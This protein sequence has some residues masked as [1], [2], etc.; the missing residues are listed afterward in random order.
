M[1]LFMPSGKKSG[2]RIVLL[3]AALLFISILRA[4]T[5]L[6][7]STWSMDEHFFI[8]FSVGFL[9]YNLNPHWFGY[10]TLPMYI[11]SGM[12]A[13]LYWCFRLIGLVGSKV[14]F[15]ALLFE[16]DAV[17][18]ISA[19]LL[20]S[21][22]H[23]LGLFVL[24]F[25]VYRYYRSTL[26]A[27]LVFAAGMLM[28]DS[29]LASN[30]VRVDS[31]VFLFLCLLILFSC[32]SKKNRSS[33]IFS[34]IACAAAIASKIPALALFPVLLFGLVIDIRQ[35]HYSK[36]HLAYSLVGVPLL[37]LLFMPY[38]VLDFGAYKQFLA[39]LTA[40]ASGAYKG[41][42]YDL[43]YK[44]ILGKLGNLIRLIANQT[45]MVA[46]AGTAFAGLYALLR[47]KTNFLLVFLYTLAYT[48]TFSTSAF[49]AS[50]W[51]RPV[52]PLYIFITVVLVIEISRQ[53]RYIALLRYL[54]RQSKIGWLLKGLGTSL[55]LLLLTGY[56]AIIAQPAAMAYY[57]NLT[58][59][60]EDTRILASSWITKY[61]TIILDDNGL[62]HYLPRI[63]SQDPDIT[64][65]SFG[66][67]PIVRLS[68]NQLLVDGFNL[69]FAKH[70]GIEKKMR[71]AYL[72]A[73]QREFDLQGIRLP[74]GAFIV[75]SSSVY[76]RY[77]SKNA[78][79]NDPALTDRARH[80]Y[81]ALKK[82]VPIASFA[83]KGP[84]ID[85]YRVP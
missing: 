7:Y 38:A 15:V 41:K 54:E 30:W 11:V 80:Y 6:H 56:F 70:L 9:N 28:P 24:A 64:F 22:I 36:A 34:L 47:R 23:T 85:I 12:Y 68:Q 37:V 31:F 67:I 26:G 20:V 77:Y 3:A 48:V 83:G 17:F 46:V 51:L 25:I 65:C 82:F 2:I 16:N 44:G 69:Y 21:F 1:S 18:Y 5:A 35:G 71:V 4:G 32:Y 50:Y 19:R 73:R 42:I 33:F 13:L 72:N 81:D 58:D 10:H 45:G 84:K 53:E 8:P 49:L 43:V 39:L 40:Q 75:I 60:R 52:Y 76:D 66:Y 63:F 74:S 61:L 55:P 14:D 29:V 59:V 62:A 79:K 27:V 57:K 78:L